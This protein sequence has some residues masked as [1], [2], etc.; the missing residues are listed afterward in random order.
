MFLHPRNPQLDQIIKL[1]CLSYKLK[2]LFFPVESDELFLPEKIHSVCQFDWPILFPH[3][4]VVVIIQ[5]SKELN[6]I[7]TQYRIIKYICAML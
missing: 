1:I 5:L 7:K 4:K 2:G 6:I 3:E